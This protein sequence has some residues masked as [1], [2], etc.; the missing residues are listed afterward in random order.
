MS[1]LIPKELICGTAK[2]SIGSFK[3]KRKSFTKTSGRR[4]PLAL[5]Y[6]EVGGSNPPRTIGW[7]PQLPIDMPNVGKIQGYEYPEEM[8]C[9]AARND[10]RADGVLD[11]DFQDIMEGASLDEEIV[12]EVLKEEYEET[13]LTPNNIIPEVLENIILEGKK[14]TLISHLMRSG[15]W[16]PFEHPQLSLSLE[17][18]TRV[19]MAQI[20]RHR[21][22]T[23]DIM[24]LRYV[25]V[26]D[27]EDIEE[28]FSVP[29]EVKDEE[30]VTRD[31]VTQLPSDIE[32][33]FI[34][35][36][37][38][39]LENYQDLLQDGV[40]AEE[41]RKVLPMGI[42]VNMVMSGNARAWMHLLN[43]RG[44]ANVQ[45]EARR[46]ADEIM[47]ECKEWMPYTFRKYDEMLPMKLNP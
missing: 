3:L 14:R 44:K 17:G 46:L 13:A 45:G 21:H 16:G 34:E 36:Y 31:G 47:E 22:F 25:S 43:I 33:K 4:I 11:H 39:A 24:S 32:E 7:H 41:A 37:E 30:I 35:A 28:R 1:D 5:V 12:A 18:V 40:P 42:K 15:H 20:T 23:F 10:Y 8:V 26:D 27:V 6:G 29:E 38:E 19:S 9:V 2:D